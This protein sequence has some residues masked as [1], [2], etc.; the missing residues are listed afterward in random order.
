MN[1]TSRLNL[2]YSPVFLK[3]ALL[4][5]LSVA[6]SG[7]VSAQETDP[8]SPPPTTDPLKHGQ[9]CQPDVV[10]VIN[11][12]TITWTRFI[13]MVTVRYRDHQLGTE[14]LDDLLR[15][16]IIKKN[17]ADRELSVTDKQVQDEFDHLNE[18][19]TKAQKG[20]MDIV[21]LLKKQGQTEKEFRSRLRIQIALKMMAEQDFTEVENVD[22]TYQTQWLRSKTVEAKV[23]MA[24]T[25]LPSNAIA[26]VYGE[27]ITTEAFVRNVIRKIEEK[28]LSQLMSLAMHMKLAGQ[29]CS[30]HGFSVKPEDLDAEYARAKEAFGNNPKFEGIHFED[31]IR[32][33]TGMS[34]D[35]WKKSPNLF[36]AVAMSHLGTKLVPDEAVPGAYAE[37]ADWYGPILEVRHV[38]IRG[39]DDEKYAGQ[40]RSRAESLK[41]AKMVLSKAKGGEDF[42]ELVKLFSDDARTK[43]N[44]GVLA[45]WVPRKWQQHEL[46]WKVVKD[47]SVGEVGGPVSSAGGYHVLKL[48]KKTPTPPISA[49]AIRDLRK[50]RAVLFFEKKWTEAKRG[51]N[52]RRFLKP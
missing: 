21:A 45:S 1:P 14:A 41:Q 5:L 47:L 11:G 23:E 40:Y 24:A 30:S 39:T 3:G 52:L 26:R 34:P 17:M 50:R 29:L 22:A 49:D 20:K 32:Q 4:I 9:D 8:T 28:D 42:D 10:A 13:D 35:L 51:V 33:Q 46:L 7:G 48:V 12:E 36:V 25:K 15:M 2:L 38:L 19:F 27:V 16:H 18:Q 44:G 37:D 31:M 6:T 43:F